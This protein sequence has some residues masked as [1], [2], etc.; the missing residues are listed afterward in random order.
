[1]KSDVCSLVFFLNGRCRSS[2]FSVVS[3][4]AQSRIHICSLSDKG[5]CEILC[6]GQI[7]GTPDVKSQV[8]AIWVMVFLLSWVQYEFDFVH[9]V[10]TCTFVCATLMEVS[11]MVL[12]HVSVFLPVAV[13]KM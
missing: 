4:E 3:S 6:L 2:V 9:V 5:S 11:W 10:C 7:P 12:V 13:L 1:M 8:M